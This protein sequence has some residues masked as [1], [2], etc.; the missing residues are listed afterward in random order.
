MPISVE[1]CAARSVTLTFADSTISLLSQSP[2]WTANVECILSTM[3]IL[4][5]DIN[6][7]AFSIDAEV[8][9]SRFMRLRATHDRFTQ[10]IYD[11]VDSQKWVAEEGICGPRNEVFSKP[12][13]KAR[14]NLWP[15]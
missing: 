4:Q 12:H 9:R 1:R 7:R 14:K 8:T 6:Q 3:I 5:I 11:P 10:S 2:I 15:G 13:K